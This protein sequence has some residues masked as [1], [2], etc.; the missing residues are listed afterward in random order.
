MAEESSAVDFA[1]VAY[2]EEGCWRVESLASTA[3]RDLDTLI[4]TLR[5]QP[6]DRGA[7]GFVSVDDDFF[8]LVRVEGI[9]VRYLLSD[10]TAA[11][12]WPLAREVL[13][14]LALPV[15]DEEDEDRAQPAGDLTIVA[16][17]GMAAMDMG[18]LCDDLELYPDEML[19]KIAQRLGCGAAFQHAVEAAFN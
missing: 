16:D 8:V 7:I 6:G 18:A 9:D 14:E 19:T 11:T 3:A 2:L 12:E 15:P 4:Q 10:V 17:L 13:D 5:R 1:V